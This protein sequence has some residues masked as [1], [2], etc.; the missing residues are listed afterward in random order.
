MMT[1]IS[2]V[3]VAE[4]FEY[5][6]MTCWMSV[7]VLY[8]IRWPDQA[9]V[10]GEE[11]VDGHVCQEVIVSR[12]VLRGIVCWRSTCKPEPESVRKVTFISWKGLVEPRSEHVVHEL[13]TNVHRDSE[14]K[15]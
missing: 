5:L 7:V 12:Y 4:P 13:T 10:Q 9:V 11:E 15:D 14:L 3:Y 8:R 2:E 6:K 1:S